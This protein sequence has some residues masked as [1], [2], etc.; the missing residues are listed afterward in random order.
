MKKTLLLFAAALVTQAMSAQYFINEILVAPPGDDAPNE[1]IELRGPEN[2]VFPA[3]TYLVQIEGDLEGDS[4]PGDIESNS[5]NSDGLPQGGIIDLGGQALGSNGIL[6][7][8]SSGNDYSIDP[9]ATQ[10]VDVT[11]GNLEDKSHTFML[12]N[13]PVA[14]ESS[15]DIDSDDDGTPDGAVYESW[16]IYDSIGFSDDDGG[17]RVYGMVNFV[18]DNANGTIAMPGSTVVNTDGNEY[19][20]AARINDNNGTEVTNDASTSDFVGGDV[21]SRNEDRPQYQFSST[22]GR[23]I[24]AS[25]G[26]EVIEDTIGSL[27]FGQTALTASTDSFVFSSLSIYPNPA[28]SFLTIKSNGPEAITGAEM[29]DVLGKRVLVRKAWSSDQI[30][31]SALNTGLY[32]L[33]VYSNDQNITRKIVIQ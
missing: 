16:T 5:T 6:V 31:V 23:V 32:F 19:D 30:N 3:G 26:G 7:I 29:F 18:Q 9:A 10:L 22:D 12:I 20:Y 15:D 24:P 21:N 13:A 11:D 2:G 4:N 28:T 14:P 17:E 27:N 25:F 33:K 1:Y 8:V